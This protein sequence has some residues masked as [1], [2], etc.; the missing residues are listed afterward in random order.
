MIFSVTD[1]IKVMPPQKAKLNQR[2]H[3]DVTYKAPI[4]NGHGVIFMPGN[5]R[6]EQVAMKLITDLSMTV[7][8]DV[9]RDSEHRILPYKIQIRTL[10]GCGL[11]RACSPITQLRKKW[12][13]E[14]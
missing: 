3:N 9:H 5:G 6:K 11:L 4:H 2:H 10:K 13:Y 1:G 7:G 12:F 8:D 14:K